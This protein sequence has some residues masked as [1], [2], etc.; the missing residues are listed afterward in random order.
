MLP[1]RLHL[2]GAGLFLITD[3]FSG[4]ADQNPLFQQNKGFTLAVLL[5]CQSWLIF[6]FCSS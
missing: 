1:R 2:N 6:F 4:L 3:D 5:S